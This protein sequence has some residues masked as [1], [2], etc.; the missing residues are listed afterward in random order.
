MTD[1]QIYLEGL[2]ETE[3][4]GSDP[5]KLQSSRDGESSQ[6]CIQTKDLSI[7]RGGDVVK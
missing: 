1:H 6:T 5:R 2:L 3:H 4:L 7:P